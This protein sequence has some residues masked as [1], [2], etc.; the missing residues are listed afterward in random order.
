MA[1]RFKKPGFVLKAAGLCFLGTLVTPYI[2]GEWLAFL[3]ESRHPFSHSAIA[4][5]KPATILQYSTAFLLI[6][7][8]L[9]L[10]FV[11]YRPRSAGMGKLMLCLIF[12]LGGMAVVKF[13]PFAV[14]TVAAVAALIW[15]RT[16]DKASL[17]NIAEGIE[18]LRK[19]YEWLPPQGLSFLALCVGVVSIYPV[20]NQPLSN[21]ASPIFSI[22]YI[23]NHKLPGPLLNGFGQGGYVMYRFSN[24]DGTLDNLVPIDGRTNVTPVKV[25][26]SHSDALMGKRNWRSFIDMVKPNT[27]V[28]KTESPLTNILLSNREW[29]R[30]FREGTLDEGFSVFVSNGYFQEHRGELS[31]DN[32]S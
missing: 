22:D 16:E 21:A 4:E 29:C 31:S 5:F 32:C 9:L 2:G 15:A 1:G 19:A 14:I 17:G 25:W 20:W 8:A 28:W 12:S 7:G 11:H 30:V 26:Q 27:I 3:Q 18:R 24:A 23:Q 13:L 6:S 10:L